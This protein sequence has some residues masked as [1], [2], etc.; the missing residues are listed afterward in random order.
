VLLI[1][2]S[3]P[4][5]P[6]IRNPDS[7]FILGASSAISVLIQIS[8]GNPYLASDIF[9]IFGNFAIRLEA[10]DKSQLIHD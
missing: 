6:P 3:F 4:L 1:Q 9:T 8:A 10:D 2:P 7:L 5:R